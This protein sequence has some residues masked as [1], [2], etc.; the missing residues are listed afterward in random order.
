MFNDSRI[1]SALSQHSSLKNL[2]LAYNQFREL[3]HFN[4]SRLSNLEFLSLSGNMFNNSILSYVSTLSSLKILYLDDIRLK[5][6]VDLQELDSL[7]NLEE[8]DMGGNEI[9]KILFSKGETSLRK[10]TWLRLS[11]MSISDGNSLLQTLGLFPSL[12]SL[13]F[14]YNNFS[15]EVTTNGKLQ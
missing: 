9:K 1:L 5:G 3:N 4:V 14:D 11:N 10:L 13:E 8:L 2:N 6:I 12:D 15:G 7:S